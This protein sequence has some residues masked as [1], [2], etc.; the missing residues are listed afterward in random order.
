[1]GNTQRGMTEALQVRQGT[2]V[3]V[4]QGLE[5]AGV[6]TVSRGHVSGVNHRLK[7]Y[8]LTSRGE[9]LARDARGH[10]LSGVGVARPNQ[11]SA[12]NLATLTEPRDSR[13]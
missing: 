3:R 5:S 1:M 12:G 2:L 9:A 7:V 8:R 13:G 11:E 4:L 10:R 6:L